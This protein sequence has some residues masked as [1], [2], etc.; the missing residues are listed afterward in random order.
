[1]ADEPT[2]NRLAGVEENHRAR[3]YV[4]HRHRPDRQRRPHQ[5]D[6]VRSDWALS[7]WPSACC[8]CSCSRWALLFV[9]GCRHLGHPHA[10]H[11]GLRH[12]QLRLVDRYRPRGHADFRHSAAA[13]SAVAQFHQ[14][15]RRSHDAVCGGLRGHVP[16]SAPGPPLADVLALPVSQHH[17]DRAAT[18][19]ARWCGTCSRFR[20]TPRCRCCSGTWA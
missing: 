3:L 8:C 20:R 15:L 17:G 12:H 9:Q 6:A 10:R 16:A 13:Q 7:R 4:R 18:S 14:P 2:G 1:M 19:A 11:V 5:E